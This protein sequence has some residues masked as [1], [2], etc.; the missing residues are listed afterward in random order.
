[1][2][3]FR[4]L[5]DGLFLLGCS[6]YALNRWL[7]APHVPSAFLR[8]HFDDLLLIPCALPVLLWM[9]RKLG[10][11]KHDQMPMWNE[12]ALYLIVWSV[13]FE[14]I[15]PHLMPW[16]VGDSRDVVAYVAGGLVAGLWW[17]RH[18]FFRATQPH[19]L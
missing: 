16:T 2:N 5:R 14:L 1:M 8:G 7:V 17:S 13:L 3:A 11:R 9:Q 10:L 12:I 6:F 15:G 18:M 4:Y 19:E